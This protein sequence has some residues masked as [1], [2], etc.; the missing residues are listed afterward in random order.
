MCQGRVVLC[1]IPFQGNQ[2]RRSQESRFLVEAGDFPKYIAGNRKVGIV[3]FDDSLWCRQTLILFIN[4]AE[5]RNR[6]GSEIENRQPV[7]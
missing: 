6:V 5:S 1:G 2:S 7:S 4:S 3:S